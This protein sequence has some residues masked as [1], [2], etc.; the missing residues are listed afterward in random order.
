MQ[1]CKKAIGPELFPQQDWKESKLKPT[2]YITRFDG[3]PA[4]AQGAMLVAAMAKMNLQ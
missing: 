2:D 3:F 1:N 4:P